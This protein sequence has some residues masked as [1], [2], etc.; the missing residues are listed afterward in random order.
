MK[1]SEQVKERLRSLTVE[2]LMDIRS[3]HLAN[4]ANP[5]SHWDQLQSRMRSAARTTANP[6]EWLTSIRKHLAIQ[7]CPNPDSSR[8]SRDL[9]DYVREQSCAREWLDLIE[10]EHGYLMAVCRGTA[11]QRKEQR[12]G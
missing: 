2:A 10:A 12:N 9:A 5:L 7:A 6:E 4:G 11:E 1:L 3:A 8:S